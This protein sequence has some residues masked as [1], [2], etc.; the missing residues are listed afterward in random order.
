MQEIFS[1]TVDRP[2]GV[3]VANDGLSHLN[4]S[5]EGEIV[6]L[7]QE[8]IA[9]KRRAWE[10]WLA[11]AE[12]LQVGRTDVMR[13]L[14]TND[15]HGRRY[16]KAMSDWLVS[17]SFKKIDK[18]TRKRLLDCL[19]HR[20]DIDKWRARLTDAERFAFNHP[21]TV[22]RKW[23]ASTVVPDPNEPPKVTPV[24]KLKNSIVALEEENWRM[25]REIARGGGDLWSPKDSAKDIAKVLYSQVSPNKA[26]EIGR[27]LLQMAKARASSEAE[28]ATAAE[29]G[30]RA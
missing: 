21:D 10:D 13:T 16:E 3:P 5:P 29:K 15:P 2:Q 23:K 20:I 8:A 14:H 17:H 4:P 22:L 27:A 11:I 12:A 7:G 26:E 1:A 9:R 19:A 30:N 28:V 6:R 25:K 24:Q 18:G